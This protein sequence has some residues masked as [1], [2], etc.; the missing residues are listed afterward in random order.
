MKKSF[1]IIIIL[2]LLSIVLLNFLPK[3]NV[4]KDNL[5]GGANRDMG[6]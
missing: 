4:G 3:S 1:A 5:V 6:G 2:G